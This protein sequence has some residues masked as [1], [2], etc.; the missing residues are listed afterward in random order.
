MLYCLS[1]LSGSKSFSL[2]FFDLY[3]ISREGYL[4]DGRQNKITMSVCKDGHIYL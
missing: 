4:S 1:A 2:D 3:F